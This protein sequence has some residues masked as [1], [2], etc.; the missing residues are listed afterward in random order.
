MSK[1]VSVRQDKTY[2]AWVHDLKTKIQSA[3]GK[4]VHNFAARLSVQSW[5][6]AL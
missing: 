4:A 1:P 2:K 6:R 3:Q 5:R